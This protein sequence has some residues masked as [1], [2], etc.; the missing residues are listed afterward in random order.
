M[1]FVTR[2]N[3]R[4]R[5][6]DQIPPCIRISILQGI[7]SLLLRLK[8]RVRDLATVRYVVGTS[9]PPGGQESYYHSPK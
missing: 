6:K 4:D 2:G 3:A 5:G 7:C 9:L 1:V 8:H